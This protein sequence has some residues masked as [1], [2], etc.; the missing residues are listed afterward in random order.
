VVTRKDVV[1]GMKLDAGAMPYEVADLSSVWVL[2]DVYESE[3][4]FVREGMAAT[5]T[6]AAFPDREFK[7]KVV[8]LD[9]LLDPQTRTVKV[10]VTVPNPAGDL[11]PD[12]FGEVVLLGVPHDALRVPPDAVIDSGTEKIVFVAVGG[13][14]FRPRVVKLGE[15]DEANV[16]VVSGLALGDRVVVRANFL[17]DSESRLRASLAGMTGS[18]RPKAP[19][20]ARVLPERE[21]PATTSIGHAG[22]AP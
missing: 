13:G 1:D 22:H 15:G 7:G 16:E 19:E 21:G 14:K 18:G 8:F 4:R 11:R 10:R 3:L 6:L 12:M 9:P 17:V 2:A 5:L 20:S